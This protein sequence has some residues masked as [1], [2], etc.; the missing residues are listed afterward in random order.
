MLRCA[1]RG[2]GNRRPSTATHRTR[3]RSG[4]AC[5]DYHVPTPRWTP[6]LAGNGQAGRVGTG[7]MTV[8]VKRKLKRQ[9]GREA[10]GTPP[11]E[12]ADAVE[13]K[14]PG[15]RSIEEK[16]QAVLDVMAGKA[17]VEQVAQRLS[18]LPET[19]EGF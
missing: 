8:S 14:R 15:K 11:S 18:V 12:L 19:V 16:K 10:L 13:R 5:T 7:R 2:R 3:R 17:T 6:S 4:G 1:W 9:R